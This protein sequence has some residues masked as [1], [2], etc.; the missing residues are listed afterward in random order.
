VHAVATTPAGSIELIRSCFSIVVGLPLTHDRSAPALPVSGPAQRSLRYSL[1][2]RGVAIATLY[3]E[4]FSSF[5][6]STA[7][8]IATGWS[9][10]VPGWDLHPLKTTT[11]PQR[12]RVV[13]IS[14]QSLP[15]F[16]VLG[17]CGLH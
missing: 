9:E 7:V 2:V 16:R 12:T 17:A 3:I 13:G 14:G 15:I 11:F 5:V 8:S 1:H 6:T 4:G 10:P